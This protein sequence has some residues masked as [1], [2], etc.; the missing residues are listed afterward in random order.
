[1]V[2]IKESISIVLLSYK[3]LIMTPFTVKWLSVIK[4]L[5]NQQKDV[6]KI[7]YKI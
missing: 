7:E 2:T 5:K 6:L 4:N 3:V 1:M